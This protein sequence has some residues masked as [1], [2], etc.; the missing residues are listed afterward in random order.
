M[1]MFR[2]VCDIKIKR[3]QGDLSFNLVDKTKSLNL[4]DDLGIPLGAVAY[5]VIHSDLIGVNKL[6]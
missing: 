6:Q 1:I 4:V 2:A 5:D 3:A